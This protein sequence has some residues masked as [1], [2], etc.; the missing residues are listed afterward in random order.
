MQTDKEVDATGLSCP[1]PILRAKKA[2]SELDSGQTVKVIATDKGS[3]RDFQEFA[4]QT[5]NELV[6]Q[7]TIGN[8]FIHVLRRR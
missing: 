2:L 1:L 6:E 7:E 8:T 4:K 3:I 5:G